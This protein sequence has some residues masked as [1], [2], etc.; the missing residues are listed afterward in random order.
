MQRKKKHRSKS[1]RDLT[2]RP[3]VLI[4]SKDLDVPA[5]SFNAWGA[6]LYEPSWK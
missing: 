5:R 6:Y 3:D 2:T 1:S 4:H